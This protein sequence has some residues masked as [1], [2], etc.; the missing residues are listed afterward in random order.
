MSPRG[1]FHKSELLSMARKPATLTPRCELCR[2]YKGCVSPKM[3]VT[4]KGRLGV[5]VVAEAPG[6]REDERNTQLIGKAGQKLRS[7]LHRIDVDLDEDCWKTNAIICR[8][9]HNRTPTKDELNYCKPNYLETIEQVKPKVI[10]TLGDIALKHVLD[11]Y[12]RLDFGPLNRWVGYRIP[13]QPTNT[14]ICPTWHPSYLEREKNEMMDFWCTKHLEE[15][16]KLQSRPWEVVPNYAKQVEQVTNAGPIIE[17]MMNY[18]G[19]SAVDYEA[20][21]LKPDSDKAVLVS[22]SISWGR[23]DVERCIAYVMTNENAA[24]TKRYLRSPIPKIAANIKFEHR[25]SMVK[26]GTPVR[27]WVWDTMQ[28]AHTLDNRK[29]VAG[30]DF[31]A[32]T[33]LG[34]PTYSHHIKPLLEGK[35]DTP[36]NQILSEIS[37]PQLLTYNGIDTITEFKIAVKQMIQ[38]GARPPWRKQ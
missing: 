7:L 6:A 35:G 37:L 31:I 22:C 19:M 33:Q 1:F 27:N 34:L 13:L 30:L 9:P 8:P 26:L 23:R 10:I 2:L 15:A 18:D 24:A 38:L 32:F 16:F 12:W 20:N 11:E 29:G 5:L 36:F 3:P 17:E 21:T 28:C 14:W 4:G 25:W